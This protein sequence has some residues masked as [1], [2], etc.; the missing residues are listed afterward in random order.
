MEKRDGYYI[1]LGSFDGLHRGHLELIEC[2]KDL[3][4]KDNSKSMVFTFSNH[5]REVIQKKSTFKYLMGNREKKEVLK[6]LGINKVVLETFDEDLMKLSPEDF[7]KKLL[8]EYKVLGLVVG[9]NY[10]FGFKNKGD[11]ELLKELG[12]KYS[13]K[14]KVIEPF[15]YDDEIVSSTRIRNL[16]IDGEI[17]L[18]N[19]MLKRPYDLEGIV[20]GGKRL[21]RTIGFPTANLETDSKFVIPKKG[22]YYTNVIYNGEIF[23]GITNIGN[24]PTVNGT[25]LTIE[26]N[27]LDFNKDIYGESLKILFLDRIRGEKKFNSLEELMERLKLDK[28]IAEKRGFYSKK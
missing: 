24:N 27:I 7:I 26:T 19:C 1:A 11:I 8:N 22:V 15:M 13:F 21:G 23:K 6:E 16:L 2:V 3:A 28:E 12:E 20:V 10:R 14:V 18:A 4:K 25:E 5:P 17:Q 9:F